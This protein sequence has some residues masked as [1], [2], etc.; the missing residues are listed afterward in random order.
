M[1]RFYHRTADRNV[2]SI[3]EKGIQTGE[4]ADQGEKLPFVMLTRAPYDIGTGYSAAFEVEIP[5]D[6]ERLISV[7]PVWIE[8]HQNV[9]KEW[10][11]AVC[12]P[13]QTNEEV[14]ELIEMF[15]YDSPQFRGAF[16]YKAL[17]SF[18]P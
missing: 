13:P 18:R 10:L 3:I 4:V 11:V 14:V 7:N 5:E 9:P 8:F 1:T 15:G 6:S 17:F 16:A 2:S 12:N